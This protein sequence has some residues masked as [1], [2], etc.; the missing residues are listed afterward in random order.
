VFVRID[1]SVCAYASAY[2]GNSVTPQVTPHKTLWRGLPQ[3]HL[4][5]SI[6]RG[7]RRVKQVLGCQDRATWTASLLMAQGLSDNAPTRSGYRR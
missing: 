4:D 2:S 5:M 7:R 6:I 1:V 3:P